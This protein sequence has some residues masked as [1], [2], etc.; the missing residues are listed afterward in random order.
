[1]SRIL[2]I[3]DDPEIQQ[4]VSSALHQEGFDV[5]YAFSGDEGYKKLFSSDPDLVIL[6]MM[7][8]G[9]SG[10]EVLKAVHGHPDLRRIPVIVMTAYGGGGSRVLEQTVR[11]LGAVEYLEKPF[12]V[13]E[14]VRRVKQC[15][16]RH[17]RPAE[18]GRET[19]AGDFR[20]DSRLKTVRVKDKLVATLPGL[21]YALLAALAGAEGPMERQALLRKVWGEESGS[22]SALEKTVSRL[23]QDLGTE[24]YRLKTTAE[25]YELVTTADAP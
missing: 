16:A 19:V 10:A 21:R 3:E 11:A 5:H 23:R 13:S 24:A 12:K 4:L 14:L 6:D 1:M 7:L 8:P 22:L 25:G 20:L 15:L 17:P 18:P 2:S 9:M